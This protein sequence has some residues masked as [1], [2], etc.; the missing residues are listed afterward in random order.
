MPAS[1]GASCEKLHYQTIKGLHD[2]IMPKKT[3]TQYPCHTA[4]INQ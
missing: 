4:P 2:F 3:L 1:T